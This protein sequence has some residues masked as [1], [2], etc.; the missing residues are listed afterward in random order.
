[1]DMELFKK[2]NKSQRYG[3]RASQPLR[4]L[5]SLE[6][7]CSPLCQLRVVRP[8][9][10]IDQWGRA[11]ADDYLRSM[12]ATEDAMSFGDN[13]VFKDAKNGKITVA[14]EADPVNG[15]YSPAS[16]ANLP[17]EAFTKIVIQTDMSREDMAHVVRI[18][19]PNGSIKLTKGN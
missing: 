14:A 18:C 2:L 13:T 10:D 12:D 16:L 1:M 3:D 11:A 6:K 8:D 15:I 9:V 19:K 4:R 7:V 5:K 17:S